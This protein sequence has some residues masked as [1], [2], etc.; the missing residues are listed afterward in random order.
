MEAYVTTHIEHGINTIEFFH[1]QSNSLPGRI[2]EELA[3]E[4]H[5]AGTHDDTKVIILK[6]GGEKTFC[7]GASFDELVAIKDEKEGLVF[8]SGF[9]NVINAMR[10]VPNL[11]LAASRAVVWVVVLDWHRLLI[12]PLPQIRQILN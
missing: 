5:F 6:S 4:I 2:L 7:S 9:A 1:P 10:K 3:R 11:S 8:F 12:M